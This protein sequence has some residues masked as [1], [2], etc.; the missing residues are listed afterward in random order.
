MTVENFLTAH[1]KE[2]DLDAGT[3]DHFAGY[4]EYCEKGPECRCGDFWRL[5]PVQDYF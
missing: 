3:A 1:M 2:P 5:S 4:L